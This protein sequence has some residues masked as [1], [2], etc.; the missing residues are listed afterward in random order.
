M[1]LNNKLTNYS[2]IIIYLFNI[3]LFEKGLK[4]VKKFDYKVFLIK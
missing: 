2:L 4:H 1:I 3:L